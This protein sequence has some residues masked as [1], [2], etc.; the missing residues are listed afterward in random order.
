[1]HYMFTILERN[2]APTLVCVCADGAITNFGELFQILDKSLDVVD[3]D[4]SRIY[5]HN[6][7]LELAMK[8]SYH[9]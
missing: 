1:M 7:Q 8:D 2:F 3:W 4:T 9:T 5:C 6:H